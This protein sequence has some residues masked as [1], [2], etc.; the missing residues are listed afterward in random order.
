[1]HAT[2]EDLRA[3]TEIQAMDL[4][5]IDLNKKFESMPQRAVILNAREKRETLQEKIAKIRLLHKDAAK[6]LAR[7]DDE[8][9]SLSKKEKGVQAAIEAAGND[10]RNAEARAKELEGISRRRAQLAEDRSTSKTE[11]DKILALESQVEGALSDIDLA[12][13]KATESFKAEGG[14]LKASIS[15]TQA[16]RDSL[17]SSVDPSVADLYD[18]TSKMFDTVFIGKLEAGRCSVCRTAVEAGRLIQMRSDAPLTV[19][20]ACKRLLIV[21]AD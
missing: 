11:L 6:R 18:K 14:A 19:C 10:F 16:Q 4:E 8:D 15:R 1:M 7:I 9:A 2:E 12:E 20:P 5:I 17:L 21:D 3:L 13:A